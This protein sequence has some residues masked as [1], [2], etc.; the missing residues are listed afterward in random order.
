MNK[1][2]L[3]AILFLLA[4]CSTPSMRTPNPTPSS[5]FISYETYLPAIANQINSCASN[6]PSISIFYISDIDDQTLQSSSSITIKLDDIN[7]TAT[8]AFQVGTESLVVI[9]NKD[10]P[11]TNISANELPDIFSGQPM[12]V[13]ETERVTFETLIYPND[14]E[15]R[16]I[17]E[18]AF[19]DTL[20]VASN[21]IICPDPQTV[22]ETVASEPL[23]IGYIPLSYLSNIDNKLE[24]QVQVLSLDPGIIAELT[25][26][27]VAQVN[28]PPNSYVQSL[29]HCLQQMN[30]I[31]P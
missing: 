4:A 26:P 23:A 11:L 17:F 9:V 10:H 24:N 28:Q 6:I 21:A 14:N 20:R 5:I 18:N 30:S 15:M 22:I 7:L 13:S 2:P 29:L 27:I 19:P 1:L 12:Q 3:F 31:D 25:F 16:R 8:Q